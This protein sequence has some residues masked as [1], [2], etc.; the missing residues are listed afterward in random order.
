MTDRYA[1]QDLGGSRFVRYEVSTGRIVATAGVTKENIA[2]V[3]REHPAPGD[4][5]M[6]FAGPECLALAKA[7]VEGLWS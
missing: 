4:Q 3:T 1:W 2:I 6:R 5:P 7:Y